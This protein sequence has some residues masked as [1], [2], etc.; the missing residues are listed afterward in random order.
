MQPA[1]QWKF[2]KR[3]ISA[4]TAWGGMGYLAAN[5]LSIMLASAWRLSL[6]ERCIVTFAPP[7]AFIAVVTIAT[8]VV[9]RERIVFF[10]TAI[11]GVVSVVV[12]GHIAGVEQIDHMMDIAVLGIG[13]FLGFG[14]LGCHAV[15]CCH[16]KPVANDNGNNMFWQVR[17]RAQHHDLGLW[18]R[19]RNRGLW[20]IQMFE[21][22]ISFSLVVVALLV[23][24]E[25]GDATVLFVPSY[26]CVRFAL[27]Y[28]RGDAA[29]P[30]VLGVSEAQWSATV[31][32]VVVALWQPTWWTIAVCGI[33]TMAMTLTVLTRSRRALTSPRHLREI[34][35]A[36]KQSLVSASAQTTSIGVRVSAHR[37]PSPDQRIDW[38]LS[39]PQLPERVVAHLRHQ[40]WPTS[41]MVRGKQPDIV[42]FIEDDVGDEV[43]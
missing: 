38:L 10:Q 6:Y 34:D 43:R 33:I 1:P 2:G 39:Y 4:Y 8:V 14:R 16:G 12:A 7:L 11:A 26:C 19:Y 41:L 23:A 30:G 27:E 13:T 35:A 3:R 5:L 24:R 25:P 40:I 29:R 17:Y 31:V 15:S 18:R 32:A 42:H 28:A 21:S 20:P 22:L 36:A 37:M 9:G